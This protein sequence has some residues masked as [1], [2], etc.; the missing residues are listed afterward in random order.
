MLTRDLLRYRNQGG[1]KVSFIDPAAPLLQELAAEL[2][3]AYRGA[4]ESKMRRGELEELVDVLLKGARDPKIAAGLNKLLLDRTSFDPVREIDYPASRRELFTAAAQSLCK[5]LDD[6]RNALFTNES[7][8]GFMAGDIYGDLPDNERVT[9]FREI[10]Q[11]ELLNRYNLALVQGLLFYAGDLQFTVSDSNP[12][13]LRR[14]FKYLKFFRL[15]AEMHRKK[16]KG[17][18]VIELEVSGPFAIFQNSRK[19]ALQLAAFFPAVVNLEEWSLVAEI[20]MAGRKGKLKLDQTSGLVSH[21]RNFSSYVPEEIRMFHQLFKKQVEEWKIVGDSP[22]IDGGGQEIVFPDLSFENTAGKVVHLE[23]FH[24]W[25]RGGLEKR[26]ALLKK[27]PSLPLILGVDRAL[28]DDETFA[29]LERELGDRVFRF[30][31]FPGVERVKNTLNK[32]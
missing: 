9:G 25:H 30:R 3:A 20:D 28:A 26:V 2:I 1:F 31:D 13:E 29:M 23:L 7:F 6:Y 24:R 21:Y 4:A 14:L 8:A 16:T 18:T 11:G 32:V 27:K 5:E 10:Y 15:L 22:F 17:K 19:Y 12:A